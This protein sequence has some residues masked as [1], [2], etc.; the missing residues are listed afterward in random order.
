MNK[1]SGLS[2]PSR[3]IFRRGPM[4]AAALMALFAVTA[5]GD[6]TGP[7][8][9]TE[10]ETQT[11]VANGPALGGIIS[12]ESARLIPSVTKNAGGDELSASLD[13][14]TAALQAGLGNE[15]RAAIT[16]FNTAMDQFVTTIDNPDIAAELAALR[17]AVDVIREAVDAR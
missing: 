7:S 1:P 8:E 9:S 5:C 4:Y 12:G 13:Q 10:A 3:N 14:L 11:V 15:S 2:V 16:R 17:H 6:V